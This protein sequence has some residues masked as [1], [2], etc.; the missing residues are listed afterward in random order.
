MR[1]CAA[2]L[3]DLRYAL[4]LRAN[5]RFSLAAVLH[6]SGGSLTIGLVVYSLSFHADYRCRHSGECCTADW[7]VPVELPVYRSLTDAI[8]AGRVTPI[9]KSA[10][11]TEPDLPEGAGAMLDRTPTGD[12]VFFAR[13]TNLCVVH[14]DLGE[15]ALPAT[16]RH[17]PR[18]SVRDARG[19]F[20]TLSHFCPTA[21]SM[22]FRDDVAVEII[23]APP[24]FPPAEYEGLVVKPDDWPPLLNPRVL[25]DLEG[26]GA[27]ERHMVGR[28]AALV[29]SPEA[30]LATL[31]RDAAVLRR[32]KPGGPSL[33]DAVAALPRELVAATPHASLGPSLQLH[34][35]AMRAVPDELKPPPDEHRLD[36]AFG[37]YV[38]PMWPAFSAPLNRY[39][40]AKAFATWTAYQGRGVATIVRGLECALAL[41]RVEAA[42]QCRETARALDEVLL[43]EAFRWA[44]FTLN[45]LA[46]GDELAEEWSA[47]ER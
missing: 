4:R 17:F 12:C 21:A 22:L 35:A 25:M 3:H 11:L 42:R 28:C 15:A 41:V 5:P 1:F 32:W 40:A 18:L 33:A 10:F 2:M 16:C 36:E 46:A 39:L 27:W 43:L 6:Q 47:M 24:A 44:D 37:R 7:D 38:A 45:H 23:A 8:A 31:R 14:R 19:T 29:H 20:I 13:G 26:Y 9:Q 34:A 30:V